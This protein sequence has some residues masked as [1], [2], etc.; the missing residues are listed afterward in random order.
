MEHDAHV[1]GIFGGSFDP[2]HAGHVAL[3]EA[4][5]K[6]LDLPEIWVIPVG[7]PVHR[8]LSGHATPEVRLHWLERIFSAE[9]F[10]DTSKV[11]VQDWEVYS[12]QQVATIDTLRHIRRRFPSVHPVLLLG[13]DAF[14]GMHQWVEY[15]EHRLL[16]DVAVFDR[17]GHSAVARQE[18]KETRIAVWKNEVGSGRLLYVK[19]RLPDISAT[20][21]RQQAAAGSSL[22]GMVPEC[23]CEEIKKAYGRRESENKN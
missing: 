9:P 12:E 4:A 7:R 8:K 11:R 17:G 18:W 6:A 20:T 10:S 2:P 15:P 5:L 21:V 23:V 19:D 3:V 13:A 16:C 14:V 22:A 1:I